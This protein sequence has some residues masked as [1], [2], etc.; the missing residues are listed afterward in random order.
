[1]SPHASLN[2][3]LL[4]NCFVTDCAVYTCH[5]TKGQHTCSP[6]CQKESKDWM[7]IKQCKMQTMQCAEFNLMQRNF[8]INMVSGAPTAGK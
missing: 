5:P 3:K 8:S 7:K 1:M 6:L 4:S 2:R